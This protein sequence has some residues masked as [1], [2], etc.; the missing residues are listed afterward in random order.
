MYI[1]LRESA[2]AEIIPDE[3]PDFPGIPIEDRYAPDFVGK[4]IHVPNSTQVE[5]NW[6]YD[7]ETEVFFPPAQSE[8]P[9]E[10]PYTVSEDEITA[11]YRE[12]VNDAE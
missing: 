9:A 11:A 10:E 3:H 1:F 5:Q 4:L 8:L 2:V 6:I 12:G 7:P